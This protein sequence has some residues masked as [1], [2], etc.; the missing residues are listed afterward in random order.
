V[1]EIVGRH[2]LNF[3][4]APGN[5]RSRINRTSIIRSRLPPNGRGDVWTAVSRAPSSAYGMI[6]TSLTHHSRSGE[7][8]R[9]PD[10]PCALS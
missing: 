9:Q 6:P 1:D 5:R 2:K 10:T 8:F 4:V 7:Q 3:S